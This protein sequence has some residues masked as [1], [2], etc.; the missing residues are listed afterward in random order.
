MEGVGGQK[1]RGKG[2]MGYVGPRRLA[3]SRLSRV[4]RE[5]RLGA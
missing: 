1:I 5:S 3:E 4:Q 2:E